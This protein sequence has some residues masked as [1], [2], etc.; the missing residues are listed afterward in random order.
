MHHIITLLLFSTLLTRGASWECPKLWDPPKGQMAL[1]EKAHN[2]MNLTLDCDVIREADYVVQLMLKGQP[3]HV[4]HH[5]CQYTRFTYDP[6]FVYAVKPNAP[7]YNM[8]WDKIR[9]TAELHPGTKYGCSSRMMD[10]IF[11]ANYHAT[12][13]LY[14]RKAGE[15]RCF[16]N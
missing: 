5:W 2:G 12:A 3:S 8:P 10:T 14:Q 11:I 7:L 15:E 16:C 1:F 13:C 6:L 9:R 4:D